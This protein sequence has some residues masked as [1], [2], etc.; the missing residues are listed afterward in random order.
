MTGGSGAISYFAVVSFILGI[1]MNSA[2]ADVSLRRSTL[3]LIA[4][5]K[6]TL[7]PPWATRKLVT[8]EVPAVGCPRDGQVGPL[9][10]PSL[11]KRVR[12]VV[13][14]GNTFP[15]AYYSASEGSGSGMVGPKGWDCF[16]TYGSAGSTLYVVPQRTGSPILDRPGELKGGPAMMKS[17]LIGGTS[18]RFPLAQISARI[19][20]AARRF[21]EK[22]RAEGLDDPKG[23]V[24]E[25]WPTDRVT[26]L[27][28]FAVSYVTPANL[29][30]LGTDL[31]FLPGRQPIS[32]LV[33]LTDID[34]HDDGPFLEGVAVRLEPRDQALYPLIAIAT[35]AS[36]D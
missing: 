19:F 9:D 27:S 5:F 22:V 34:Q 32:G 7:A 14:E 8:A 13:P 4:K 23:Y 36:T 20:P 28:R 29:D 6:T 3:A 10:P 16:G 1:C 11:P 15:L 21:V 33:F 30:G 12:V 26:R 18:G 2:V 35:I 17:L 31:G 25:P 24:F